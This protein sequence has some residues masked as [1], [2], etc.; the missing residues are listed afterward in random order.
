ML[1]GEE[2]WMMK[3]LRNE[4]MSISAIAK[5]TGHDRKTVRK[6]VHS[7]EPP[8][9]NERI[10]RP[11]LLDPYKDYIRQR[12]KEYDLTATRILR[13]IENKGYTG[14]YWIL[15]NFIRPIREE[16]ASLAIYRYETKPGDQAQVDLIDLGYVVED[17]LSKKL[18]GFS[19]TLGYSRMK[20]VEFMTDISTETIIRCHINGFNF[21]G[22]YPK[23]ILYD[24]T[25]QVVIKRSIKYQDIDWNPMFQ[26]FFNHYGFKPRLCR[27]YRAQTKGKIENMVKLVRNDFFK[28]LD[29]TSLP[30]LNAKGIAWCNE[31]N[32][33]R[34]RTTNAV[35]IERLAEEKLQSVADKQPY[36]IVRI[37]YR[38]ISRDCFISYSGNRYSVPWKQ[39]G[40]TA[41]LIIKENKMTVETNG[42]T[43]CVH[44]LRP[45]T[46]ITVREKEHF[47]GLMEQIR[48]RNLRTHVQ[49]NMKLPGIPDVERRPLST[50][51]AILDPRGRI[52]G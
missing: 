8:K 52:D 30:D 26:D 6:Y 51:D 9:Y 27:P 42:E 2:W 34:H 31:V 47:S 23:E 43:I 35:P 50:Y 16:K 7:K 18:Y 13:E 10:D 3:D 39:A 37:V 45:G 11:G 49:R 5:A 46:G 17:N 36:M 15:K 41:R 21:F 12:V 20:F 22:G 14:G 19:M 28:G 29:F 38:K 32:R 48:G 1:E 4:G 44:E 25:K 24:N 40:R 33:R